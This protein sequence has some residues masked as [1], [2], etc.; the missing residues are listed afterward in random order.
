MNF[1]IGL[2]IGVIAGGVFGTFIM[3]LLIGGKHNDK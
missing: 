2:I 1:V 3:A